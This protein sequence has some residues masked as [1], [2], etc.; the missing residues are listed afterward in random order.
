MKPPPVW[1]TGCWGEMAGQLMAY[2]EIAG[3][4][5]RCVLVLVAY[6]LA[7]WLGLAL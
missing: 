3:F 4:F 2:V 1:H 5:G 6:A 7:C